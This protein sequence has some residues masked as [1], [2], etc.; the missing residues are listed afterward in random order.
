M[1]NALKKLGVSKGD[2]VALCLPNSPEY[3]VSYFAIV[4]LGAIAVPFN[5]M[6]QG[7]E[8]MYIVNNSGAKFLICIAGETIDKVLAIRD[9]SP[10]LEKII[11]VG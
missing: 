2:R 8:I 5:W 4:K 9:H 3:L 1:G 10:F 6:F 11:S 7:P